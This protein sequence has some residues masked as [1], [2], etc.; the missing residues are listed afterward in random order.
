M[1]ITDRADV[2][3]GLIEDDI[4][5]ICGGGDGLAIQPDLVALCVRLRAEVVDRLTVNRYA[6]RCY[7]CLAEAP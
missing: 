3:E 7:Q 1:G 4:E 2:P 5:V 6:T